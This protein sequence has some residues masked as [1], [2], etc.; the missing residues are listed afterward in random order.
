VIVGAG[1]AGLAAAM[2]ARER[3]LSSLVLEQESSLGGSI[4]HYPRRKLVLT[5][6]VG[7]PLGESIPDEEYLKEDLVD[8]FESW[9]R[10]HDLDL[11]LGHRVVDVERNGH[12]F[13]VKTSGG[14]VHGK[15]VVLAIGRRGTPRKLGVPGEDRETVMYRLLDA[16]SYQGSRILVVGGGDSAVEAAIG[17]ARDGQ[18]EVTL[19]YR[20]D[21]LLRIKHKNQVKIDALIAA[22]KVRTLFP[23]N[24]REIDDD[25]VVLETGDSEVKLPVD[26]VFVFIGG[27]PHTPFLK[28][29]GMR[30]G[31]ADAAT[32]GR[33]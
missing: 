12:G 33:A 10:R 20:R 2:A 8:L 19:S 15:R 14:T 31:G 3:G 25:A 11:R 1:P 26:Y 23:S 17:L 28:R 6:P 29:I 32:E 13:W 24:V 22:G 18:N 4:L 9:V 5:Q 16:D 30:F 7:M 21:R 27:E